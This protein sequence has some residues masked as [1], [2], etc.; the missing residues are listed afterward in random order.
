MVTFFALQLA[1]VVDGVVVIENLFNWPG[2]GFLLLESIRSRDLTMIQAV[3][4]FIG[5]SYVGAN[6]AAD[7]VCA[8]LDPRQA[9]DREGL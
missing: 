7:L 8:W 4:L 3:T 2:I 6:L 9:A 1:H 5:L